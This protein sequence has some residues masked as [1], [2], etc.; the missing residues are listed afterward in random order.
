MEANMVKS[1]P[2]VDKIRQI[3]EAFTQSR[4]DF[5][6]D[7]TV[8][9]WQWWLM[10][11]LFFLPWIV[12]WKLVDKRR[13]TEI[14]LLGM[15]I[16]I[17]ASLLDELGTELQLWY[18]PFMPIPLY[19]QLVPVNFTVL[20]ITYMLIYQFTPKW[21]SYIAATIIMATINSGIGEPFLSYIGIYKLIHWKYIYSFPIYVL[22]AI[23]HRWFLE[24]MLNIQKYKD[25]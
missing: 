5:W 7:E 4:I 18:Y 14:L 9:H 10:A 25:N 2:N 16:L 20:P 1:P 23:S 15:T 24:K 22:I 11:A 6:L 3:H 12:W 21:R 19:P 8:W 13:I 17:T